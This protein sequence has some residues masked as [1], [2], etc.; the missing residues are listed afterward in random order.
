MVFPNV[1]Y[2]MRNIAND[3]IKPSIIK[4]TYDPFPLNQYRAL[5]PTKPKHTDPN[6]PTTAH[7]PIPLL[8]IRVE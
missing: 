4:R 2:G 6:L 3:E 7:T 1:Q 5:I 8:L